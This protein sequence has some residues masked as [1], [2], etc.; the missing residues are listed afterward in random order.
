MMQE[1][2]SGIWDSFEQ[3]QKQLQSDMWNQG[4]DVLVE[5]LWPTLELATGDPESDV[6]LCDNGAR[7]YTVNSFK[8]C[9][10]Q[11]VCNYDVLT[12]VL[13]HL[14]EDRAC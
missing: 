8:G 13:L 14:L 11:N 3:D 7:W 1:C 9:S 10:L 2:D 5:A 12:F 4:K 6:Y